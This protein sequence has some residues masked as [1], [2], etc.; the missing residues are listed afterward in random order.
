MIKY[1]A[2]EII[3]LETLYKQISSMIAELNTIIGE[4]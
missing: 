4:E 1:T 3:R 2:E